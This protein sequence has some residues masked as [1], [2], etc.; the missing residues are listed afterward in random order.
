MRG[1][2]LL[3]LSNQISSHFFLKFLESS[4]SWLVLRK[5]CE[6]NGKVIWTEEEE[7][8]FITSASTSMRFAWSH[9]CLREGS[10]GWWCRHHHYHYFYCRCLC[11]EHKKGVKEEEE[12]KN[13]KGKQ[14]AKLDET[15]FMSTSCWNGHRSSRSSLDERIRKKRMSDTPERLSDISYQ[16][17]N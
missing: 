1:V 11:R 5:R 10:W 13:L 16:K 14:V 12:N 17:D 8:I 9:D 7:E 15:F 4:S 6:K 3:L 2:L